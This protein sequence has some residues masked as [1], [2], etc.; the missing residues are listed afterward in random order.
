MAN[1]LLRRTMQRLDKF[2]KKDAVCN[3]FVYTFELS[4]SASKVSGY[5]INFLK[6]EGFL[7]FVLVWDKKT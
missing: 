3:L 2:L 1:H 5:I 7:L 6:T 4:L